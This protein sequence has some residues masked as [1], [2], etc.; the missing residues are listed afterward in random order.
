QQTKT[1]VERA[2][3][4]QLRAE[5]GGADTSEFWSKHQ[6]SRTSGQVRAKV[7]FAPSS[8][9]ELYEA[10]LSKHART[11]GDGAVTIYPTVGVA[12]CTASHAD[13]ALVEAALTSGRAV[14]ERLG[15]SLTVLA[16]PAEVRERVDVYGTLPAAF[17]LMRR[18]KERFDPKRLCNPGRFI[19]HL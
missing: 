2:I 19:G 1:C 11:F 18:I 7:T 12:F 14:A 3:A 9:P 17:P 8:L 15:G 13:A 4:L 5:Q 6:Q 16:A 10:A